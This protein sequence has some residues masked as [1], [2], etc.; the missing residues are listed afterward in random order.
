MDA[1][2]FEAI[3]RKALTV[4][5]SKKSPVTERPAGNSEKRKRQRGG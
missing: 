2:E 1:A 3:M 5:V 4:P